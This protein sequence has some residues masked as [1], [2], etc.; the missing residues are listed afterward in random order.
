MNPI[1]MTGY[2]FGIE[3]LSETN[4]KKNLKK[5]IEILFGCMDLDYNL[6]EYTLIKPT[7]SFLWKVRAF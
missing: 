6:R 2:L 4:F 1:T 5:Q 3:L 7:F